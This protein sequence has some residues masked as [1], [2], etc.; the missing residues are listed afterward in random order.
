MS[1]EPGGVSPWP[2]IFAATRAGRGS[3]AIAAQIQQAIF[4]GR[5]HVGDRLP[6]ERE[7]GLLLAVSRSTLR[8][9]LRMLE[10]AGVVDIR[11]GARGGAFV[12]APTPDQ[13]G[14]ALAALIRFRAASARDFIE[15]RESF[16]PTT[17]AWAARRADAG[18]RAELLALAEAVAQTARG[19]ESWAQFIDGDLAFHRYLA[20]ASHNDIRTAVMLAMQ[21]V[22]HQS[23]RAIVGFDTPVWR[24][25]QAD[26]LL[27]VAR[28]VA[29][30]RPG[31]AERLM[32]RHVHENVAAVR[33]ILG[34]A[35]EGV[36]T[37]GVVPPRG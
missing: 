18:E 4:S 5:L 28:A 30:R 20:T 19:G 25:Q 33:E 23:S 12:A 6:S 14:L 26:E 16:E 13:A 34:G 10:A 15:F 11:R 27:A 3:D 7:L 2:D 32:R 8:E 36:G 35:P 17:A 24:Q 21:E 22:F 9:A 1:R 37:P 29:A 31:L